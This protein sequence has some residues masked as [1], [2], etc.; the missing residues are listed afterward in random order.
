MDDK[1]DSKAFD[2]FM[3]GVNRRFDKIDRDLELLKGFHWRIAGATAL[4]TVLISIAMALL[5]WK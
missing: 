2:V 1:L 4:V 5:K 3:D